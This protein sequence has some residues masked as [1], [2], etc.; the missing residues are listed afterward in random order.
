MQKQRYLIS[1]RPGNLGAGLT[2]STTYWHGVCDWWCSRL[3]RQG[4]DEPEPN[5]VVVNVPP[6]KT[7]VATAWAED[8]PLVLCHLPGLCGFRVVECYMTRQLL[9]SGASPGFC[10]FSIC[11]TR[12]SK[13]R[14]TFSLYRALASVHPHWSLSDSFF[15]SSGLTC[16]CS[17]RRSL[18]L[19]TMTM[20]TDS[21]PCAR[22]VSVLGQSPHT[23]AEGKARTKWFRIFSRITCTISSDGSDPTEYTNM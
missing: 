1:D 6:G 8:P 18:L 13:A 20:G 7:C 17:G 4:H 2:A 23:G 3:C 14:P 16:R 15:P 12:S 19:P 5:G 10:D 9:F 22:L 21:V 11:P